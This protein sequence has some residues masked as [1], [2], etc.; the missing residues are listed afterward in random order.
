MGLCFSSNS[1]LQNATYENT[2]EYTLKGVS[3]WC[4]VVKVYDGDTIHIAIDLSKNKGCISNDEDNGIKR[5]KC[6]LNG[7][8]A[9]EMKGETKEERDLA[10]L[11]KNRLD[12]LTKEKLVWV[13]ITGIDLYGR[14]LANIY[15]KKQEVDLISLKTLKLSGTINQKMLD[16]KL[17]YEYSGKTKKKFKD[18]QNE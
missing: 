16:E 6:R 7:I 12:E 18:W 2:S 1:S 5:I 3:G 15:T 9:P 8:D 10:I 13:V 11:S 17:A 4:K 14:Y